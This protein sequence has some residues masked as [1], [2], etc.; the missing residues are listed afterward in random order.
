MKRRSI[1]AVALWFTTT[2]LWAQTPPI[3]S[4]TRGPIPTD[5][6]G[7]TYGAMSLQRAATDADYGF[8][9]KRPVMVKGGF[10]EGGHNVYRFLN[11]LRG[12]DGQPVRYSRIG[13]CCK[14]KTEKSPF[15][16]EE[17]LEV[18][19]VWYE[20]AMPRRMYFNWY[21]DGDILIPVGFSASK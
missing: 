10:G 20:G 7:R 15:G 4:S 8:T 21:D 18:Y 17:L 3:E 9:E 16:G 13:T 19:E 6:M 5:V 2:T 11:A 14:F 12:P 1:C